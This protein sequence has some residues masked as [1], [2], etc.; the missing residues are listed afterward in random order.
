MHQNVH[1]VGLWNAKANAAS[2]KANVSFYAVVSCT[3]NKQQQAT[4]STMLTVTLVK[5][6]SAK[7]LTAIGFYRIIIL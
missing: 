1:V 4:T 7:V 6:D 3:T 2:H 5:L